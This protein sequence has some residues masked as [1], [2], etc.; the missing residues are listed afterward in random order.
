MNPSGGIPNSNILYL[1]HN[2]TTS[3][4][5]EISPLRM[6]SN[7]SLTPLNPPSASETSGEVTWLP[8]SSLSTKSLSSL[9][10][11]VLHDK[12]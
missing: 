6:R 8:A 4:R 1:Y 10:L 7:A 3:L 9:P 12:P 11:R 5:P 2:W